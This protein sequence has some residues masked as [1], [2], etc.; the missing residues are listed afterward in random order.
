VSVEVCAAAVVAILTAPG[1]RVAAEAPG[2]DF[3]NPD[4]RERQR[5]QLPHNLFVSA[6]RRDAAVSSPDD[7]VIKD[8]CPGV[9]NGPRVSLRL[10]EVAHAE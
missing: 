6:Q 2:P 5:A 7:P 1:S 10:T 4:A 8:L 9:S 3:N